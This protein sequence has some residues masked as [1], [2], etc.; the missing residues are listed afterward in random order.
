M[1]TLAGWLL[2]ALLLP[3][4]SFAKCPSFTLSQSGV[5]KSARRGKQTDS[6]VWTKGSDMARDPYARTR[7]QR[8][9][10]RPL[11]RRVH[12]DVTGLAPAPSIERYYV[13]RMDGGWTEQQLAHDISRRYG[14][15][16]GPRSGTVDVGP[17]RRRDDASSGDKDAERADG[18]HH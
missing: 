16:E 8:T 11:V 13:M 18:A 14:R 1:R 5:C 2:I 9:D 4:E 15:R 7:E 6:T 3:T 17:L 12:A 10:H